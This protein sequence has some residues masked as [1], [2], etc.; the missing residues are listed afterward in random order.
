MINHIV[1]FKFAGETV[2]ERLEA[3][4]EAKRSLESLTGLIPNIVSLVV[5]ID[6]G[7]SD[8]HWDAVL[9]SRFATPEDLDNY[10]V[11]PEH[12]RVATAV[13]ALSASRSIVDYVSAD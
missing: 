8:T 9:V 13:G 3:A 12:V 11:H 1:T 5:G 6:P 4:V 2:T 7:I 10:Q